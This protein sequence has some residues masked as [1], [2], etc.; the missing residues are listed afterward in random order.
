MDVGFWVFLCLCVCEFCVRLGT[1]NWDLSAPSRASQQ[2]ML[3]HTHNTQHRSIISD[4]HTHNAQREYVRIRPKQRF[5]HDFLTS[6]GGMYCK[7]IV[8]F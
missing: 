1:A 3:V 4:V 5:T 7:K 8:G 2:N 6:D